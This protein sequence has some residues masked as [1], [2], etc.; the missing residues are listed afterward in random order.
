MMNSGESIPA[1]LREPPSN[2]APAPPERVPGSVRRTSHID[3]HLDLPWDSDPFAPATLHLRGVARDLR[4][5]GDGSGVT[6]GQATTNARVNTDGTLAELRVT[7]EA[8]EPD[9]LIGARVGSGF[10][11]LAEPAFPDEVGTP[12][13]L[14]I[15][16]LPVAA[17]IAG[18][19]RVRRA[20]GVHPAEGPQ[21]TGSGRAAP[22]RQADICAGWSAGGTMIQSILAGKGIPYRDG[23]TAPAPSPL[24]PE[25]WHEEPGMPPGAMRRRRRIDVQPG[26]PIRIN[27]M[28]RDTWM[29]PQG[30]EEVLHEY[31]LQATVVPATQQLT[32]ITAEPRALPFVDCVV[33]ASFVSK[34]EGVELSKLR[35][36]V[37][38]TLVRTES[39]THLNDLLRALGD[40]PFLL[41]QTSM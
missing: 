9:S 13:G 36:A 11:R 35:K 19:A 6:I 23:P 5:Q 20:A 17:L 21:S 16:D 2:P 41:E 22:G 10:R 3:M 14:L 12:L 33:A 39:C 40:V 28:F 38:T 26:D 34:L 18:Y 24:D 4:T 31:L 8:G 32:S 15:D 27:A 29:D 25:G 1:L 30:R 7:P 37:R